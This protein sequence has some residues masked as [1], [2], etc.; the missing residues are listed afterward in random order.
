MPKSN[1][2]KTKGLEQAV[3]MARV[4]SMP[5]LLTGEPGVGKSSLAR[6]L[7]DEAAIK[8]FEVKVHSNTRYRDLFY[9]FDDIGRYSAAS[10]QRFDATQSDDFQ[11]LPDNLHATDPRLFIRF[12]GLGSAILQAMDREQSWLKP[13]LREQDYLPGRNSSVV[14]IDEID[15]A[16]RDVPNDLL[17][18]LDQWRFEVPEFGRLTDYP[19]NGFALEAALDKPIIVITSN[20]EKEL[21]DA[22]MRRCIF[23]HIDLPPS[24]A[25]DNRNG[26]SLDDIVLQHLG[27]TL[28][29]SDTNT[30]ELVT[31]S[32]RAFGEIRELAPVRKPGLAELLNWVHYMVQCGGQENPLS[33]LPTDQV[34]QRLCSLWLKDPA[35]H[36]LLHDLDKEKYPVI[37]A[38]LAGAG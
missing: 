27:D 32:I 2:L 25:K 37:F 22:F 24:R 4:L 35:D 11:R 18:Q 6:A 31:Q 8:Y 30:D 29:E 38:W 5:L 33:Q 15:K 13:A 10:L 34:R 28:S 23:Y 1:Y 21:P 9:S 26:V 7:A 16:P 19:I 20:R 12:V 17:V 36:Q 14:L 3:E